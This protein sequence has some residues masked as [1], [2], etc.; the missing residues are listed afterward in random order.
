MKKIF[1]ILVFF[2]F[3]K[4]SFSHE[5]WIDLENF[6]PEKNEKTKIF[7]CSGHYFPKSEQAID[8][9]ILH[10]TKIITPSRK[11]FEYS[12]K[13]SKNLREGEYRFEEEGTYLILLSIKRPVTQEPV[14]LS[15]AI[16]SVG[17]ESDFQYTA[18]QELEI[19][20]LKN[21]SLIKKGDTLPLKILFDRKPAKVTLN[22]SVE[23]KKNFSI[24]SNEKGEAELKI[25]NFGRYLIF[26]NY[27]GKGC[28]LTFYVGEK[29]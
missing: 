1:L 11:V 4:I 19:I 20:P 12:T 16:V 6:T 29:K 26:T 17:R 7:I 10:N 9:K 2:L 3:S 22:I 21:I 18:E 23:G 15:K 27:K 5:V 28:S 25:N 24:S 13:K 14:Y 8:E